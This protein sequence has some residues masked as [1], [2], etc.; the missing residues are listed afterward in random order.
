[1][2]KDKFCTFDSIL[3]GIS[4]DDLIETVSCNEK[5]KDEQTV[6]RVFDELLNM[7]IEDAKEML[8]AN[9]R[10]ILNELK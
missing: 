7:R 4:Y 1:M 2:F 8:K 10:N 5:M 9:M 3:D 6:L